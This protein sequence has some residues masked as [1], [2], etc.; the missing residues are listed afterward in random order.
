MCALRQQGARQSPATL[1]HA[2]HDVTVRRA[3]SRGVS[4][5]ELSRFGQLIVRP[6]L[7]AGSLEHPVVSIHRLLVIDFSLPLLTVFAG[8]PCKRDP[9]DRASRGLSLLH[10]WGRTFYHE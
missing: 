3:L 6:G 1:W 2:V 5:S 8:D 4:G 10:C 7:S 9:P